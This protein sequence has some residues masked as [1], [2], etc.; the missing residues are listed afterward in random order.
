MTS[1]PI[2]PNVAVPGYSAVAKL[3][4]WAIAALVGCQFVIGWTM[5]DIP[6]TRP[7]EGL[8]SLHL[9][10]GATIVVLMAL[11]LV[12]RLVHGVPPSIVV[13]AWQRRAASAVHA[14][15]YLALIMMPLAGWAWASSK[16]WPVSLFGLF[17]LPPLVPANWPYRR[18]AA[19]VHSNGAWVILALVAVHA[20]AALHH[21]V[22]LRDKVLRRMLWRG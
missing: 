12:W 4:H 10:I 21:H 7:P 19:V 2:A 22:V 8:V 6:R 5:P 1:I 15:L 3:L 17:E 13:A 20:L 11:R 18:L 16:P 9:S 14:L